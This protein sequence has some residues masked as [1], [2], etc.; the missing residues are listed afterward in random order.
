MIKTELD[1]YIVNGIDEKN[2]R[3][4]F[5]V[6]LSDSPDG[7]SGSVSQVSCEVAVRAIQ[8]MAATHPK[9]PIE[10][11]MNSFGGDVYSMLGLYDVIQGVPYQ[12]K[13]FGYGAIMS[14]ASFIMC[15]CDERYL[16]PNTTVMIHN[17]SDEDR[18]ILTDKQINMDENN[19]LTKVLHNIYADN[20]RMPRDFWEAV[21]KRNLHLTAEEAITLGLADRIIHPKKRGNLRKVRQ[22]HLEQQINKKTIKSL[23]D[24]LFRR[25]YAE[26]PENIIIPEPKK[27][28]IDES[29]VIEPMVNEEI[30][31]GREQSNTE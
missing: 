28:A 6:R 15:G 29:L 13:F 22:S 14:A 24:R 7:D 20:S 4:F 17:L 10:I 12:V 8:R 25:I 9:T 23:S 31:N 27:E 16:Y 19:R 3:I 21:C 5:G 18:G 11:H 1:D 26:P 2:R 30:E